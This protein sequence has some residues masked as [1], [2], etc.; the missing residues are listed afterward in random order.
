VEMIYSV[1]LKRG[2]NIS[3]KDFCKLYILL[4]LSEFILPTRMGLVHD[5]LF[6]IVDDLDKLGMY[7]WR[8]L[9]YDV[10]VDSL[11]SASKWMTSKSMSSIHLDGC[12]YLLQVI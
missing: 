8:G 11:C 3:S 6:N 7:N 1:I 12:V 4:G 2:N 5:G 9:V 10:L